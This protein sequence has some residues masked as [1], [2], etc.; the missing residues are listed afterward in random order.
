LAKLQEAVQSSERL[1]LLGQVSA[2]LAHQ[3]RNSVTGAILA[4]QLHAR[5]CTSGDTEALDVALRQLA[6]LESNLKRFLDLGQTQAPRLAPCSLTNVL[7]EAVSL[8]RPQCRHA[9]TELR[10]QPPQSPSKK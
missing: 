6:L 8:L 4:V 1:R 2:G 9:H 7:S 10:W 5:D 3:L